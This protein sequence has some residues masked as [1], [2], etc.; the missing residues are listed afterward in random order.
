MLVGQGSMLHHITFIIMEN[1]R[2]H[3]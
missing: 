2:N 1:H 3:T